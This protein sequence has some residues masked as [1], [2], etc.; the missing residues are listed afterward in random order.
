MMIN[1]YAVIG[2]PIAHSKSPRI[3]QLFAAQC[4]ITLSYDRIRIARKHFSYFQS[5]LNVLATQGLLGCNITVPFKLDA[6]A[7]ANDHSPRAMAAQAVNTLMYRQNKWFG[8]NTDGAGLVIDLQRLVGSL[9]GATILIMGAGGATQG[10]VLP[11]QQ[12]GATVMISN[13]TLS[14]AEQ[15]ANQFGITAYGLD[16]PVPTC[17]IIVNASAASLQGLALPPNPGALL[18]NHTVCYDMMYAAQPT[19]FME[20]CTQL[21]ARSY[22]G[23]GMLLGQAAESFYLWHGVKPDIAPVLAAMKP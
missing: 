6:F 13:R 15:L 4:G 8:D 11:L 2:N 9:S 3:H 20:L 18:P 16:S 5:Q 21:G 23:F 17:D 22:D 1:R 10:C 12:A 19:P 7:L 14:K